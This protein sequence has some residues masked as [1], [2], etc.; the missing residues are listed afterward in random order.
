MVF[1]VFYGPKLASI[2]IQNILLKGIRSSLHTQFQMIGKES[3]LQMIALHSAAIEKWGKYG[4]Y[5]S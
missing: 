5:V 3:V 2:S 4:I 1:I